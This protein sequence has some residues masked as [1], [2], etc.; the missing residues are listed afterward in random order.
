[1]HLDI[2]T[3]PAN[4]IVKRWTVDARDILPSNLVRYQRDRASAK[5][6]SMRHSRLYIKALELVRM[7]DS[8]IAAYDAAMD[9]L[10]DTLAKVAPLS[11]LKDG[12]GLAEREEADKTAMACIEAIA[13]SGDTVDGAYNLGVLS[14]PSRPR[15]SGRPNRSRAKAPYENSIKRSRF[16]SICRESGHKSTTCPQRGDL[17]KKERKVPQ[18]SNCGLTGHRKDT[19]GTPLIA[20]YVKM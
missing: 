13:E 19:C 6:V 12:L 14:A 8:N 10:V 17:P 2:E 4:H 18:C 3:I 9:G 1:M 20:D 7:G 15:L 16:C 11:K 5:S